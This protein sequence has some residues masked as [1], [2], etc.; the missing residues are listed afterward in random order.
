M[1]FVMWAFIMVINGGDTAGITVGTEAECREIHA[2][3]VAHS[4][5][6]ALTDCM[7]VTFNKKSK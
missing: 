6:V 5:V 3:A 7:P 4:D 1:S 2:K